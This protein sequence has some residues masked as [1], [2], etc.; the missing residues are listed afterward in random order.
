MMRFHTRSS[1]MP[2]IA[3]S[4]EGP[5]IIM[6]DEVQTSS[7]KSILPSCPIT[8]LDPDA[9]SHATLFLSFGALDA[10]L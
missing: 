4:G 6:V 9:P 10:V 8:L 5:L 3:G 2:F 1:F 7:T